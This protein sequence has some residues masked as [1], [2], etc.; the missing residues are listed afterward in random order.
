MK[1]KII[2]IK[3]ENLKQHAEKININMSIL[4][5]QKQDELGDGPYDIPGKQD[6]ITK[7][8][9][10][11]YGVNSIENQSYICTILQNGEIDTIN[12]NKEKDS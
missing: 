10:E 2:K 5:Q 1:N 8:S 4:M 11:T 7:W 3:K 9:P 12:P 6:T